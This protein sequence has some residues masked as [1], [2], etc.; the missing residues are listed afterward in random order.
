MNTTDTIVLL[1]RLIVMSKNSQGNL[2]AA[3]DEA[4]STELKQLLAE[5]SEFF[6]EAAH[7]MQDAVR[8]LGGKPKQLA[9]FDST[10]HRT[11][12]HIKVS[13]FGRDEDLILD[14][15]EPDEASAE[16]CF[17]EAAHMDLDPEIHALLERSYEG[18]SR[19]HHEVHEWRERLHAPH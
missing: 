1:N 19:R 18:A 12:M 5:Y 8:K 9:T 17:G 3:A 11:W 14:E 16:S 6:S 15:V 10:L 2:R 7:E 4:H 13:A